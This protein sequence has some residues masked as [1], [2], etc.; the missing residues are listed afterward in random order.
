[1]WAELAP[2]RACATIW[3]P[4]PAANFTQKLVEL[5]TSGAGKAL[6]R[7][8]NCCGPFDISSPPVP[9]WA[10][11]GKT[12]ADPFPS[13]PFQAIS[14]PDSKPSEKTGVV[15]EPGGPVAE[16]A[17]AKTSTKAIGR[18]RARTRRFMRPKRGMRSRIVAWK[19]TTAVLSR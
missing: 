10:A 6:T 2:S 7:T 15:Y 11:L 5:S 4:G 14:D 8:W 12:V 19:Q 17:G 13:S 16:P 18:A 1:M 9:V 3:K